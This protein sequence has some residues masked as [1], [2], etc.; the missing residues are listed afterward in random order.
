MDI[1]YGFNYH[2]NE[3]ISNLAMMIMQKANALKPDYLEIDGLAHEIV[4]CCQQEMK[5]D[6]NH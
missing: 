5:Y 4:K 6:E 1:R 3:K 2:T